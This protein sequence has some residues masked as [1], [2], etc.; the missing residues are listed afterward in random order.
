ME[1]VIGARRCGPEAI[2]G[3]W[4]PAQAE[5]G[6]LDRTAKFTP[7]APVPHAKPL[8][9]IELLRVLANN[10]LE[11]WTQAHFQQLIVKG[12]LSIG[13]AVEISDPPAVRHVLM[14]NAGNY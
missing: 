1:P 8:G 3:D 6:V 5:S 11:A 12:G 4:D 13:R 2:Q 14:D 10:P 9:S 7:P